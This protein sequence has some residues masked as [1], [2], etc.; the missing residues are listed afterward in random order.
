VNHVRSTTA[1]RPRVYTRSAA[2]IPLLPI[3]VAIALAGA[4]PVV[5]L[6]VEATQVKGP[7]DAP[8]TIVEFSDY[9]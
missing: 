5:E 6:T 8:V 1:R 7:R 4:E 2:L 3:L 9:Q